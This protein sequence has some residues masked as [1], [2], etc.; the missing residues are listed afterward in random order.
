MIIRKIDELGR[1]CLPKEMRKA[2]EMEERQR[3]EI[4]LKNETIIIRKHE[5]KC[6]F[7]GSTNDITNFKDKRICKKC[8]E[9][10]RDE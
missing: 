4:E 6:T 9:E 7:C 10:L 8:L 2:L 5:D 3:L 1:T